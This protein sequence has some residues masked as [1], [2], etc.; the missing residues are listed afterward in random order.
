M[1]LLAE[2]DLPDTLDFAQFWGAYWELAETSG[3]HR[4]A[5][6][7]GA[8]MIVDSIVRDLSDARAF[9]IDIR[10]NGGGKDDASLA[11]L[12]PFV[13]ATDKAFTK[14]AKLENGYTKPQEITLATP[15]HSFDGPIFLLTSPQ[16]ASAAEIMTLASMSSPRVTRIGS[17]TEGIFSDMLD[18]VMPNGWTY[19]LSNEVYQDLNLNNYESKGIPPHHDLGY[20]RDS[21][22]MYESLAEEMKNGDKAIEMALRLAKTNH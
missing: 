11:F 12:H 13:D 1:I 2:V 18:R 8:R 15:E 20:P 19:S 16:T 22:E 14:K 21:R 4:D 3:Y 7:E 17:A 9:I 6:A 5:E 10:F